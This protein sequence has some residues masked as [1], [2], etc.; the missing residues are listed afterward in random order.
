M[1][2][3]LCWTLLAGLALSA[4]VSFAQSPKLEFE[5]A[6]VKPYVPPAGGGIRVM[7]RGGPG[8]NDPG[9]VSFEGLTL[10]NLLSTAYAVKTYQISGPGWLDTDRYDIVAKIPEGTT[11]EQFNVML[12][13]LLS[14]RFHLALHREKKD[15]PL[16]ELS[17]A[18]S[19]PKMKSSIEDPN[20]PGLGP[21]GPLPPG[22]EGFP[23]L[24]PGRPNMA[25]MIGRGS[26]RVVARVQPVSRLADM[27]GNQLAGPV[28]DKT[29]LTGT[30]D[31]TLEFAPEA[32]S[33]GL[34]GPPPPAGGDPGLSRS[35]VADG[36]SEAPN[37]FTAVQEQLGLKL[38]KKKGPLDVLVI[39]G[40]ERTPA[41]N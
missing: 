2:T 11:K 15:L 14:E 26:A 6:T 35:G 29:G 41:E 36:Q 30:Y 18:K 39:D 7:M 16:Y 34:L 17:L 13:N 37:L 31:Y 21:D 27:L 32:G 4:S 33:V 20:A 19:G 3:H 23:Q 8:T 12:Q 10:K 1:N 28:I 38:D 5:V 25:M 22:K 24:P 40:A 9:R